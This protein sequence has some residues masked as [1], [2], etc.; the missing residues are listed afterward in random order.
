MRG[1]PSKW[2]LL[3]RNKTLRSVS[4]IH[5]ELRM[6]LDHEAK[7]IGRKQS[8]KEAFK[9]ILSRLPLFKNERALGLALDYELQSRGDGDLAFPTIVAS[10]KNACCLHYSKKMNL[11][12]KRFSP[13]RFW[14]SDRNST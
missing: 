12:R 5:L 10:G 7:F 14:N 11:Y 13:F 3:E 9:S 6:V 2:E 1:L 4:E 8:S